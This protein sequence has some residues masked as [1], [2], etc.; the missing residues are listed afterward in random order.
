M[1]QECVFLIETQQQMEPLFPSL[2]A[3]RHHF[4]YYLLQFIQMKLFL[5]AFYI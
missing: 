1:K 5:Q 3:V 4:T 2:M